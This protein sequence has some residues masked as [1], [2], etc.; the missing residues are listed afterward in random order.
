[1]RRS[2]YIMSHGFM[3]GARLVAGMVDA[4]GRVPGMNR[5]NGRMLSITGARLDLT[6]SRVI[7][8]VVSLAGL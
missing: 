3:A 4:H 7:I 2:I 1:M 6:V 8:G 5:E